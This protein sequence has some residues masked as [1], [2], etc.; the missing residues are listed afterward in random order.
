MIDREETI[1]LE[2]TDIHPEDGLYQYR[3]IFKGVPFEAFL[4]TTSVGHPG[5]YMVAGTFAKNTGI[6]FI[7][8]ATSENPVVITMAKYVL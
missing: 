2:I 6:P 8:R 7:D 1:E 3:D 5:W 4:T